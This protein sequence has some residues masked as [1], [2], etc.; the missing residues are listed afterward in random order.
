M[1][2]V[3]REDALDDIERIYAWIA[4]DNPLAAARWFP[5]SATGLRSWNWTALRIWG[6]PA[7]FLARVS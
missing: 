4:K 2:V 6:G 7:W 1:R 3:F 5:A